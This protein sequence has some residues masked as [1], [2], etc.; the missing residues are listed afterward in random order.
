MST[1]PTTFSLARADDDRLTS[2]AVRLYPSLDRWS[3][4]AAFYHDREQVMSESRVI[5]VVDDDEP[6]RESVVSLMISPQGVT[7]SHSA[8]THRI[9]R[10]L[11]FSKI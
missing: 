1:L 7:V 11:R 3:V 6:I 2:E 10:T 8:V 5:L 4:A 9:W